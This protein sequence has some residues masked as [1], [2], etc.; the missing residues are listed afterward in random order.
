VS[1]IEIR[2]NKI[3]VR[4]FLVFVIK[5]DFILKKISKN[6]IQIQLTSI[7]PSVICEKNIIPKTNSNIIQVNINK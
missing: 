2:Y 4:L 3:R 5:P 6:K 1:N 7:S